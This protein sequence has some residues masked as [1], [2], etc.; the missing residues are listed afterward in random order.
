MYLSI[1]Y[2]IYIYIHTYTYRILNSYIGIDLDFLR[3]FGVNSS[4]AFWLN[5]MWLG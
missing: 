1:C 2:P 3:V 4:K 5:E